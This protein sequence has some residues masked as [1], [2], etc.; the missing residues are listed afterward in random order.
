MG[1]WRR[2]AKEGDG[3]LPVGDNEDVRVEELRRRLE[4][5]YRRYDHRF[6]VPD[7]LEF[8]RAQATAAD[9]EVVGLVA[10]GL[11]FGTVL[12]I[13][14]SVATVLAVLGPRPAAAVDGL[15]LRETVRR[16][17]TFRHRW[18]SGRDVACLL[19]FVG[20]MRASHGSVEAFFAT[21]L[22]RDD[23]NVGPALASFS[24]RALA[25]DPSGIYRGRRLPPDAGVR[26]FFPSP[27]QGSACKRLNL[28]LRW[29]VRRDGVDLGVW[30]RPLPSQ[31]VL[32][33]DAH[34]YALARRLRLTRYRSPGWAM[35]VDVTE[36]LRRF[37]PGDPVKYD[38]ALHRMGL[39][40]KE[41]EVEWLRHDRRGVPDPPRAG[42]KTR[43]ARAARG[44][45]DRP[46]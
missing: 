11:A 3:T 15:D 25:L 42:E 20:Q 10:S 35:A 27:R 19:A 22:S 2:R 31:L 26:Y 46:R 18:V 5:L 6:V 16:L 44:S 36:R 21:G 14:R 23:G 37:D 28:Y 24:S 34:T 40:R 9:R 8:V 39:W 30:R 41:D 7:P 38:F 4:E 33:L 17:R 1:G 32:P 45:L 13:K 29:M 43:P 12:Q